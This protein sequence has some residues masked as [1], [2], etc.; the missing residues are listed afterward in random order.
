HE[1]Q[2]DEILFAGTIT[3]QVAHLLA[4]QEKKEKERQ[5]RKSL[6]EKETLLTEVHHRVKNNLAVVSG[7]MQLQA[8]DQDSSKIK[9]KLFDS[10]A[11]LQTMAAI[12]ELLY[13]SDSFSELR[14]DENIRKLVSSVYKAFNAGHQIKLAFNLEALTLNINQ[15]I[16]CSL[17]INEVVTNVLK[18]AFD[19][20][21][22]TITI[23]L[24]EERSTIF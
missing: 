8:Y 4:H 1:W 6:Q 9:D 23:N 13:N 21:Q 11:R 3:D 17:I 18:H 16:P 22:G 10:V 20:D 2:S 15:A 7:M 5:I 24:T 19:D 14:L 12:H